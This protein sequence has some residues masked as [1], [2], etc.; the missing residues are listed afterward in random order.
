MKVVPEF[1]KYAIGF[2]LYVFYIATTIVW[3]C[4]FIYFTV[5]APAYSASKW[6]VSIE[7]NIFLT[8]LAS[9]LLLVF[10]V[11]CLVCIVL[12]GTDYM[13]R[14]SKLYEKSRPYVWCSGFFEKYALFWEDYFI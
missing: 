9:A 2:L 5:F 6:F 8:V 14:F 11:L 1:V 7:L 12:L 13:V 4:G 10:L 3:Y